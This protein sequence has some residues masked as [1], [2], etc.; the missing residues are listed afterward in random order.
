MKWDCRGKL[1]KIFLLILY[2]KRSQEVHESY[3]NEFCDN[4]LI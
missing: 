4:I 2:I 1:I 3:N